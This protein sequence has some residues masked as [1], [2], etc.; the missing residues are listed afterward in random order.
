M[1][2]T[3]MQNIIAGAITIFVY[4]PL[5]ITASVRDTISHYIDEI[6]RKL[7]GLSY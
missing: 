5:A 6:L 4:F 3:A 7:R 2:K 1:I